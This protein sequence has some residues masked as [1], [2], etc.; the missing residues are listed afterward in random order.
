M[1]W[2]TD[3]AAGHYR[4]CVLQHTAVY[5]HATAPDTHIH[6]LIPIPHLD[7]FRSIRPCNLTPIPTWSL[8]YNPL[9]LCKT[10]RFAVSQETYLLLWGSVFLLCCRATLL[11]GLGLVWFCKVFQCKTSSC[12]CHKFEVT[13]YTEKIKALQTSRGIFFFPEK[14]RAEVSKALPTA[15]Q[16]LTHPAFSNHDTPRWLLAILAH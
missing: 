5:L 14:Q 15:P 13:C 7:I 9:F 6:W 12:R 11:F 8:W 2:F 3:K 10:A 4:V 16:V 1:H